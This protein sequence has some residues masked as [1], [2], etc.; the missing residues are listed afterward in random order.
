MPVISSFKRTSKK[1]EFQY[2]EH[3]LGKVL[4]DPIIRI[5]FLEILRSQPCER[6][7]ILNN[8]IAAYWMKSTGPEVIQA[9]AYLFD[10]KLAEE[11]L[12]L[13]TKR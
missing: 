3:L 8:W 13:L 12:R 1:I 9:L 4:E 6:R 2:L 5:R 10:D 11:T 7:L